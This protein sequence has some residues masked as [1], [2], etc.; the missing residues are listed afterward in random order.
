MLVIKR[1]IIIIFLLKSAIVSQTTEDLQREFVE[2]RFGVFIHFGIMTFTGDKWATPNQ[3][4]KKFNPVNLDCEQWAKLA[5]EAKMKFGIL[6]TKHHDGFCLWDSKFTDYDIANTPWKNGKGDILREFVNAF[7]SYGLEPCFYYSIWDNTKGIGNKPITKKDL[8]F[9]KGQLTELLTN[10]GK[11]KLLFIDGWS[12]KMGHKEVPYDEI[13]SL[14]K[15]LQPECLLVDNTHLQCLYHNDLVHFEAGTNCPADNKLPAML[16]ILINKKGGNDWFWAPDIPNA[17]LFSTKEI[18]DTLNYLEKRWCVLVVN[19]PPNNQGRL[20]K[21][22]AERLIDIGKNWQ[23]D[24]NRQLLPTQEY[25][26]DYPITPVSVYATSG[27]PYYAIDG[28]N[29]RYFYT[30]W[31]SDENLPQSITI[32]LGK[33]YENI[34]SLAYVP[35]YIPFLKPQKD[36]SIK[37]YKIYISSDNKNFTE[38]TTGVW[39]GD[40]K[41]KIVRFHPV[42]TRYIKLEILSAVN[43]HAVITEITIG[44]EKNHGE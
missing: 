2:L 5:L 25:F 19:S 27:N 36:G 21:N 6:T 32:D 17:P 22:I 41:M 26:I 7:R 8:N 31:D 40:T 20:D 24:Y 12:W 23:P 18:I 14:V 15:K 1:T 28:I 11:I 29:D 44:R 43:N 37:S 13:R 10:Y 30:Y 33:E 35:K 3:D 42:R 38:I 9:I 4:I 16:S 34:S 39:E